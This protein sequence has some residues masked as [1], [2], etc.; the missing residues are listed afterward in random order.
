MC[1][2]AFIYAEP[3]MTTNQ[4]RKIFVERELFFHIIWIFSF[5]CGDT[6]AVNVCVCIY[7]KSLPPQP[8]LYFI[9]CISEQLVKAPSFSAYKLFCFKHI[10]WGTTRSILLP[11]FAVQAHANLNEYTAK[12]LL[13][14]Q[15]LYTL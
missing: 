4:V 6:F 5:P 8:S 15:C 9:S 10:V 2:L 12:L 11:T 14:C 3:P 1:S 7:I 13:I